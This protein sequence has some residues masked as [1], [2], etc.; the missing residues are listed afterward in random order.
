[1]AGKNAPTDRQSAF[2]LDVIELA[3]LMHEAASVEFD[4]MEPARAHQ[5][6]QVGLFMAANP[7]LAALSPFISKIS[8]TD[9]ADPVGKLFP[10]G[11][12]TL[13]HHGEELTVETDVL[14]F[15]PSFTFGGRHWPA[16]GAVQKQGLMRNR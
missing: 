8:I 1:M 11:T 4:L 13:K 7:H 12:V 5:A 15:L 16:I 6:R 14:G 9:P 3:M 2:E 10:A